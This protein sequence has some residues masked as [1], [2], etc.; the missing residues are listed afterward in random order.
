MTFS[1]ANM[2]IDALI[3][4]LLEV[5]RNGDLQAAKRLPGAGIHSQVVVAASRFRGAVID[6]VASLPVDDRVGFAKALA[7]YED[8][9]GG[10]GSVTA[11]Q[12]VMRLF[13]EDVEQGYETF[14]WIC[15][16]TSSLWYYTERA[17]DFIEPN[18]GALRRA[19]ARAEN[20]QRSYGLAAAIREKQAERATKNLYNAIRRGDVKAVQA[21]L[22]IGANP[23]GTTSTGELFI[24]YARSSNRENIAAQ[25][26]AA[27][28]TNNAA[29]KLVQADPLR[30][31]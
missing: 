30:K 20:D 2:N 11:V 8:S 1:S 6:K 15:D 16:N 27:R 22:R 21:L 28:D 23:I 5:V 31:V 26:E 10:I 18:V 24:S 29:K 13:T 17:V 7:V 9:V 3:E 12:H 4:A 14:R 19:S 25:L